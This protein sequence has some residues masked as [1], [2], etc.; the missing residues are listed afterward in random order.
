[1]KSIQYALL[2]FALAGK[3]LLAD[4]TIGNWPDVVRDAA[5]QEKL[6]I[7]ASHTGAFGGVYTSTYEISLGLKEEGDAASILFDACSKKLQ[8]WASKNGAEFS[9]T[10]TLG[11]RSL[12]IKASSGQYL[13]TVYQ[14]P[15]K[16]ATQGTFNVVFVEPG[17]FLQG[18]KSEVNNLGDQSGA[19]QVARRTEPKSERS[20]RSQP[21]AEGRSR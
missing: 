14:P 1:M 17:E 7:S 4:Q 2:G 10:N 21:D 12:R 6:V 3:A 15:K 13:S 16:G 9:T 11:G 20:D 5:Q 19:G 18:V 8:E